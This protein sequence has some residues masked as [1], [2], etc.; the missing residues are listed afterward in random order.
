MSNTY[1]EYI[2]RVDKKD[3]H[4]KQKNMHLMELL[5]TSSLIA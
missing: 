2:Q 3:Y 4:K 5:G 1:A